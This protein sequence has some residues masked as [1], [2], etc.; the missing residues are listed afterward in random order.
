MQVTEFC[1]KIKLC[2][3]N[4][5]YK[6]VGEVNQPK[7]SHGHLYFNMKDETSNI[8]C[9]V[10]KSKF[11]KIKCEINDGDKVSIE[12]K[13]DFYS[14]TGS[15]NFIVENIIKNEGIGNLQK[16]YDEVKN[17]F[18]L[19]GY[20]N[21][22]NKLELPCIIKNILII[23]S[24]SG[25]AIKDFL[26]NLENNNSRINY[27][28]IDVPVQGYEC[29]K[30]I[31]KKLEDIYN[32]NICFENKIDAIVITR[33]GGSFQDLFGF[34][35]PELIESVFNFKKFPII[36]AIGHQVDN[37]LL[38]LVA[39]IS[40]PTPSLAAQFLIDHNKNFI[41]KLYEIKYEFYNRIKTDFFTEQKRL[42]EIKN[43]LKNSINNLLNITY[44]YRN[45][46]EKELFSRKEQL[47][48]IKNKINC[49]IKGIHV[50]KE[51][52]EILKPQFIVIGDELTLLWD[53]RRFRI[54][55]L[56]EI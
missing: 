33:G 32:N 55:I 29:H 54:S 34:S 7:I 48:L 52:I 25:A 10:W 51:N 30:I 43:K 12:V 24:E 50:F 22:K 27:T 17:N 35:E 46:L 9:I 41:N 2:L 3:P 19:K 26:F 28:I 38:D 16:K 44:G 5:K 49:N 15:L 56:S 21:Q 14:F 1:N 37:P 36:S 8:K 53:N 6:I 11:D 31:S 20:F 39:D 45:L 13:L 18:E 40:C 23:T 47:N 42:N 4:I